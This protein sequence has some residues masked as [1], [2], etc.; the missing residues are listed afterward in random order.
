MPCFAEIGTPCSRMCASNFVAGCDFGGGLLIS[1]GS[2]A[3]MH[4]WEKLTALDI[5]SRRVSDLLRSGG[6][7]GLGAGGF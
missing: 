5:A 4:V 7:K 1:W 3:S 6:R 2:I